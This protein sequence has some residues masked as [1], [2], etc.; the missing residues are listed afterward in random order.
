MSV[1]ADEK[2]I[3]DTV[4]SVAGGDGAAFSRLIEIF[5][6]L[7][8]SSISRFGCSDEYEKENVAQEIRLAIFR[9]AK[10]F[11]V[12]QN[13]V[14]FGLYAKMCIENA[15]I[16]YYRKSTKKKI[17]ICSLDDAENRDIVDNLLI[18]QCDEDILIQRENAENLYCKIKSVLSDFEFQVFNLYVDGFSVRQ[19]SSALNRSEKSI[20]NAIHRFTV[21][22]REFLK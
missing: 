10:T 5:N 14:T 1:L 12:S 19:I 11:D 17:D 13:K 4:S 22:L 16:S 15:L 21:K 6:P 20:G 7:L 18:R 9:A 8:V 2:S 3:R